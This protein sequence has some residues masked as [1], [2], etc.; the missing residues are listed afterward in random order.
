MIDR[1]GEMATTIRAKART[2]K[3]VFWDVMTQKL[4]E[5]VRFISLADVFAVI[6]DE[7]HRRALERAIEVRS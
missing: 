6:E 4:D 2:A 3:E 1:N 5:G 7:D